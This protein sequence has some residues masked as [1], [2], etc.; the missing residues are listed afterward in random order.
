MTFST[1]TRDND[2]NRGN[3]AERYGAPWWF[4]SCHTAFLTGKH[5]ENLPESHGIT[6]QTKWAYEKFARY[7]CMKI[8]SNK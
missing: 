1:K 5:G 6:W 8:R 2:L 7:A 3:C 4:G